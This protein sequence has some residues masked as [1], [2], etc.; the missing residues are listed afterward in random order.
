M[1]PP[2]KKGPR[3]KAPRTQKNRERNRELEPDAAPAQGLSDEINPNTGTPFAQSFLD[4]RFKAGEPS[5][6]PGGR[7]KGSKT[8]KGWA[9]QILD[10]PFLD[11][12]TG[13]PVPNPITGDPMTKREA[14]MRNQIDLAIQ[15]TP[16]RQ[17]VE[18]VASREYP[19][20]S[21]LDLKVSAGGHDAEVREAV[22]ALDDAGM[23]AM[24]IVL[25]QLGA[26]SALTTEPAGD[27]DEVH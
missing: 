17:A 2:K 20:P 15:Q 9:R 3:K 24:D 8:M 16:D 19:K 18:I 11:P 23:D 26:K 27:D 21:L 10:E 4:A 14:F 22:G 12:G 5:G 13:E 6:N 25:R 7:P 1:T